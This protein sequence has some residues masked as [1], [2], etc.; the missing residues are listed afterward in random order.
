MTFACEARHKADEHI[1]VINVITLT[2]DAHS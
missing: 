2:A 1:N